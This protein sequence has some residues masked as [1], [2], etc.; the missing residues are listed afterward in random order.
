MPGFGGAQG[1]PSPA[2]DLPEAALA[3]RA[4][5]AF[6]SLDPAAPSEAFLGDM[7]AGLAAPSSGALV[8]GR[9]RDRD[10]EVAAHRALCLEN[11]LEGLHIPFVPPA[12]AAAI[13]CASYETKPHRD[14]SVQVARASPGTAA[15]RSA[16]PGIAPIAARYWWVFPN[17]MVSAYPWGLSFDLVPP[18]SPECTRVAFR[19]RVADASTLETGAGAGL[20]AVEREDE[21]I[22]EAVQHGVRSRLYRGGRYSPSRE[23]G[24]HHFHRLPCGFLRPPSPAASR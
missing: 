19:S 2:D 17:L 12:L 5:H 22:V 18:V 6:A 21:A 1:L 7:G 16:D 14:S 13:D 11:D 4:G 3:T 10:H 24:V 9:S 15:L 8:H 20:D 23:R